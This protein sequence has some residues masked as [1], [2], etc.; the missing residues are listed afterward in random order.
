MVLVTHGSQRLNWEAVIRCLPSQCSHH[1][2]L[3][4]IVRTN[5]FNECY[6]ILDNIFI[7]KSFFVLCLGAIG[8]LWAVMWLMLTH[9]RP[10]D[11]P[12]ISAKEKE[13]IQLNIGSRDDAHARVGLKTF[14][15]IL[16][17]SMLCTKSVQ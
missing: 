10:E 2:F 7:D 9:D 4:I 16:I 8:I 13:Y 17:C 3:I 5:T 14:L 1:S 12:R 6:G 11:H 15:C